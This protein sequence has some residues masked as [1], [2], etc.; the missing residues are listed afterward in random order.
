MINEAFGFSLIQPDPTVIQTAME[1]ELKT[2]PFAKKLEFRCKF[3]LFLT[4]FDLESFIAAASG[5]IH[6]D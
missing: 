3:G 1:S 6:G 4:E 2:R 5:K